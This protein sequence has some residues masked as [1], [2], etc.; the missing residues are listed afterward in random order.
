MVPGIRKFGSSEP[1]RALA[2][3]FAASAFVA[4]YSTYQTAAMLERAGVENLSKLP[5][6]LPTVLML[7]LAFLPWL[8]PPAAAVL[9]V[10]LQRRPLAVLVVCELSWL[11][12]LAW[13]LCAVAAFYFPYAH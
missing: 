6:P 5:L 1:A 13:P 7:D 11:Y 8:V 9:T 12:A 3:A 2:A 4:S 10:L